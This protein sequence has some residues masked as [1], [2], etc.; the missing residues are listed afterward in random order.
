[1]K[2][3]TNYVVFSGPNRYHNTLHQ[4]EFNTFMDAKV[5]FLKLCCS[6]EIN[7]Q[8]V[9]FRRIKGNFVTLINDSELHSLRCQIEEN[10]RYY[11]NQLSKPLNPVLK[12]MKQ[13]LKELKDLKFNN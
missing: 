13:R 6:S 7:R 4:K 5:Y 10:K 9:E 12:H 3:N 1:M 11:K 8:H 2:K